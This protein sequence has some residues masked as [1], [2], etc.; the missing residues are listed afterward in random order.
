M[1]ALNIYQNY[2]PFFKQKHTTNAYTFICAYTVAVMWNN[3][4]KAE[5]LTKQI[6]LNGT[7]APLIKTAR[8]EVSLNHS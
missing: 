5:L 1:T 6:L 7:A 3:Y 4:I 8:F 2:A